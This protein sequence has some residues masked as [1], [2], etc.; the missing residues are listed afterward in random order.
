MISIIIAWLAIISLLFS[1]PSVNFG[2]QTGG[3][4]WQVIN[5]GVMGGL[6]EGAAQL[7]NN[8]LVF[9]GSISLENNGGFSSLKSPFQQTDLS[10]YE[11]IEIRLRT[12]AQSFAFTLETSEYF[13]QPYFKQEF[14]S[15]S[16][17]W[18]IIRLPLSNFKAYR[19]G[20]ATGNSLTSTDLEQ[21]I[22]IGFI[23]AD[24]ITGDFTLEIDYI[25]FK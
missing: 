5:D 1:F 6:S 21:I 4:N 11:T 15:P 2:L 18:E 12:P 17:E 14:V 20:D 23:K 19:L 13:F 16:H 8:S 22:R 3:Q 24:K 25:T 10:T 9:K 7:T